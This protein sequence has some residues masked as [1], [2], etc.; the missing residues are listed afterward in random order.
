MKKSRILVL[1]NGYIGRRVSGELKCP[2]SS[3]RINNFADV[4]SLVNKFKPKIIIN[5][6]GFVGK[7]VDECEIRK[8]KALFTNTY[9]PVLLAEAAYRNR[10]KLIHI[11]S[12]CIFEYN[13]GKDDPITE[14]K[15]PDFFRLFYSRTKIY[16]ERILDAI[17]RKAN[18]LILRIRIPLD[19]KPHPRNILTKL[20]NYGKVIE[21][22]N[23]ITYVPDF[24][25]ALRHLMKIDA[26]GTYNVVNRGGLL[27]RDLLSI[28][29]RYFPKYRYSQVPFSSLGITRT[30]IILST[31]KLKK[32]GFKVRNINRVLEECVREYVKY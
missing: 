23:S 22:R 4:Q 18:I 10:I 15:T 8:D 24:L 25:K 7:N 21:L 12:G 29:Q 30:N 32:S 31:S 26:R 20:L 16:S 3:K 27:Y 2:V 9:L 13:Y 6:I 17:G 19:N 1:G 28:Y 14:N 5:C 11:S